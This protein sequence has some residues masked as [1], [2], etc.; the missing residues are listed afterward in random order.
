M[1]SETRF[2]LYS[3][4]FNNE[5]FNISAIMAELQATLEKVEL[6][7]LY[8]VSVKHYINAK[9]IIKRCVYDHADQLLPQ[10]YFFPNIILLFSLI[11]N[12][13]KKSYQ[14]NDGPSLTW[15]FLVTFWNITKNNNQVI[16]WALLSLKSICLEYDDSF[17]HLIKVITFMISGI[18]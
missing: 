11:Y 10:L 17:S 14:F 4:T 18:F 8:R 2:F 5:S 13:L 1:N 3:H 9:H 16:R 7:L 12:I 15:K 6:L